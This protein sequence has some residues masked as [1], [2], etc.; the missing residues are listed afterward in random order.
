MNELAHLMADKHWPYIWPCYALAVVTFVAL[1]VR[2]LMLL[3]KWERAA[4]E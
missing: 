1:A 2:A 3:R 4:K